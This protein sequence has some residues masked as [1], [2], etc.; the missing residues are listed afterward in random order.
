[1]DF[2]LDLYSILYFFQLPID[3]ILWKIFYWTTWIPF[4]IFFINAT[5]MFWMLEGWDY[6]WGKTK[7]IYLAIDIPKGNEK[8]PKAVESIIT[9]LGGAHGMPSAYNIYWEGYYQQSF[10]FEI[11]SMEGYIQF[12]VFLPEKG[13]GILE[14]AIYS[15]Y[16]E[17]EITEIEDYTK[18]FPDKFPDE[19]YDIWGGEFI[20]NHHWALPIRTYKDFEHQTGDGIQYYDTM[21]SLMDVCN[22]MGK[23]EHLWHQILIKPI[24]FDWP[25]ECDDKIAEILKE[26]KKEVSFIQRMWSKI[27]D[28]SEKNLFGKD[29]SELNSEKDDAMKMMNLKPKEKKQVEAIQRKAGQLGFAVKMRFIYIAKKEVFDKTKGAGGIVGY[30]KQFMD[31]DL[32]QIKPDLSYTATTANYFNVDKRLNQRKTNIILGYKYRSVDMGRYMSIMSIEE[33]A[34]LWHFPVEN[35]LQAPKLQKVDSKKSEAPIGLPVEANIMERKDVHEEKYISKKIDDND[36]Y[37]EGPKGAP[38]I[39]LPIDD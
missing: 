25:K 21:S 23:G 15:Q 4:A 11:V 8:S 29:W 13:K 1:M 27:G 19:E 5:K 34:T 35:I 12:V 3:V 38:P 10:S 17:A 26:K 18:D 37:Q 36:L 32:N 6:F 31:L 2:N 28:I 33:I 24:G 30:V 7:F 16:P 22:S 20:L 9:Y 14:S 39:N